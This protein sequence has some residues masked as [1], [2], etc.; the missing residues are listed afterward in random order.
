MM[1][2]LGAAVNDAKLTGLYERLDETKGDIRTSEQIIRSH[3]GHGDVC[4]AVGSVAHQRECLAAF[5][6]RL[7]AISSAIEKLEGIA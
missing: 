1:V 6:E 3:E 4:C 5:E 7:A 2:N